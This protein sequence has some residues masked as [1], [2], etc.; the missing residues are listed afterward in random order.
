VAKLPEEQ[1]QTMLAQL[2]EHFGQPVMPIGVYCEGFRNW[3]RAIEM[4]V[5]RTTGGRQENHKNMLRRIEAV[6]LDVTK[7]NLLY[8]LL[9][10]GETFRTEPCPVHKGEWSGCVGPEQACPHCMSGINVTGWVKAEPTR[11]D[12]M[13]RN[14]EVLYGLK[15]GDL[16]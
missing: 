11:T 8:R 4:A 12:S 9:Y 6:R 2:R 5:E 1:V 15:P 3:V 7:S 10:L 13:L 14:F 16:E